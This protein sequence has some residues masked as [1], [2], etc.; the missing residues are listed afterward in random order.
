MS[1]PPLSAFSSTPAP[2]L[3]YGRVTRPSP[4]A[5]NGARYQQAVSAT[6]TRLEAAIGKA[7]ERMASPF[8]SEEAQAAKSAV[9]EAIT[10]M[11]SIDFDQ[12]PL[13][14]FTDVGTLTIQWERDDDGVLLSFSGDGIFGFSLKKGPESSYA[15]TYQE[16]NVTES[17]DSA[18]RAEINRLS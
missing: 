4:P 5:A 18:T 2:D 6:L 13:V 3:Q 7:S 17:V 1:R 11:G 8:S 14:E 16:R 15:G 10:V 9:S 12:V